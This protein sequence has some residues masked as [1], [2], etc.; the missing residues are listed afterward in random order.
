MSDPLQLLR[1][2][3]LEKKLFLVRD[4]LVLFENVS[5]KGEDITSFRRSTR[6]EGE[7]EGNKTKSDYYTI[8]CMAFFL[9]NKNLKH[10]DYVR[11]AGS[12]GI[13]PVT[14]IDR[15][16]LLSYLNGEITDC[17]NIDKLAPIATPHERGKQQLVVAPPPTAAS[18]DDRRVPGSDRGVT[19]ATQSIS[20]ERI[21]ELKAKL[22]KRK[23]HVKTVADETAVL[24][25]PETDRE[26]KEI[27]RFISKFG[28]QYQNRKTCLHVPNCD[29]DWNHMFAP[30]SQKLKISIDGGGMKPE[31]HDFNSMGSSQ[32][33]SRPDDSGYS[34]YD[35]EKFAPSSVDVGFSLNPL[36]TYH[37]MD[38]KG[39]K[40]GGLSNRNPMN[41]VNRGTSNA[42]SSNGMHQ[43]RRSASKT[44]IILI[45]NVITALLSMT[46]VKEIFED[47]KFI[48][49]QEKQRLGIRP[50]GD[51]TFV[52]RTDRNGVTTRIKITNN[53]ARLSKDD[54]NRVIAAFVQGQTWQFKGWPWTSPA[55]IFNNLKGFY[56]KW[57]DQPTDPNVSKWNVQIIELSRTKRHL[58]K[59]AILKIWSEVDQAIL[60]LKPLSKLTA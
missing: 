56:L 48:S 3:N 21:A 8:G 44:P 55:E 49:P 25:G 41:Q 5:Y 45:P 9:K 42:P 28:R 46:N 23:Q 27:Q 35:Q 60:K 22:A 39:I 59:A 24:V 52:T 4:G 31:M 1:Q 50:S 7:D 29:V 20:K 33:K 38:L 15:K 11:Q 18:H 17:E 13:Q 30:F 14:R 16:L 37:G 26:Q 34:R 12:E 40:E 47:L 53:P 32:K 36:A 10:T 54:W 6:E 51:T 19:T 2:C 43:S 57:D 58:D